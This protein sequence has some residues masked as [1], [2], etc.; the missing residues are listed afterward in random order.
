MLISFGI[1]D[2][3]KMAGEHNKNGENGLRCTEF[4]QHFN[5]E[6]NSRKKDEILFTMIRIRIIICKH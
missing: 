5:H 3:R 6:K 1:S 4:E 2:G